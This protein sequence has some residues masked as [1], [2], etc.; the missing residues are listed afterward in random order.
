MTQQAPHI[1]DGKATAAEIITTVKAEVETMSIQPGLAVILVGSDPASSVYVRNKGLRAKECGFHSE[2]FDMPEDTTEATLLAKIDELN[3]DERIHGILVQLPL[4]KQIDPDK[5]IQAIAP[6][7]DVDGFHYENVG[8]LSTGAMDTAMVACTPLGCIH[9]IK[10]ALGNNLSGKHAVIVGRSNIVGKPVAN[11]L[12]QEN[13][14]ISVLHSRTQNP[15]AIC[16]TADIVVAAVGVPELVKASWVKE[17]AV[18]IDVGI[19]RVTDTDGNSKLVGDVDFADVEAKAASITP[20]PGG[21]GPMTI[22][23]L[24]Q[25]TLTAAKRTS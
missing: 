10:K 15:E 8:R 1:L 4:P 19:N 20:V 17:G 3:N 12:L 9:L 6:H 25:N 2:Q 16:S 5:V 21:V 22:A 24:M 13:C 14:T 23:M 7:K 11:L 18:V